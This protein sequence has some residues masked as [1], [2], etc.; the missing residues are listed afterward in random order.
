MKYER[1]HSIFRQGDGIFYIQTGKIQI[2]I[3]SE[4]ASRPNP[5]VEQPHSGHGREG[6]P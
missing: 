2:T 4:H 1:G 3:V 6:C 5:R